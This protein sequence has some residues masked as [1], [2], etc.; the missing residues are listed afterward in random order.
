LSHHRKNR[1]NPFPGGPARPYQDGA[2]ELTSQ[3]RAAPDLC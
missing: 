2:R 3:E 1:G